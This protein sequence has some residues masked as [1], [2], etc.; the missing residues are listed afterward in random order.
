[1][2]TL[3]YIYCDEFEKDLEKLAKRYRTIHKDF[4]LFK[5]HTLDCHGSEEWKNLG[6]PKVTGGCGNY[7]NTYKVRNFRCISLKQ[8]GC[9]SGIRI[10]FIHIPLNNKV[11]FVEMY[12]KN[13]SENNDSARLQRI[14]QKILNNFSCAL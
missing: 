2:T 9:R 6:I 8:K 11:Y 5:I 13:D 3:E 12:C 7:F 10:I 14:I 4:E 1:M